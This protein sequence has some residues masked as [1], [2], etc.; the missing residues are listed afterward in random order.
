M[1]REVVPH[2]ACK[3]PDKEAPA[4]NNLRV[5]RDKETSDPVEE[6]GCRAGLDHLDW[7]KDNALSKDSLEID[8][9]A[10]SATGADRA[11]VRDVFE[12]CPVPTLPARSE[13]E[14]EDKGLGVCC[15][16]EKNPVPPNL[17]NALVLEDPLSLGPG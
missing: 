1:G 13:V 5:L 10:N 8:L 14:R 4:S 15:F 12:R 6:E 3:G 11:E 7:D 2:C 9:G 17:I 16:R